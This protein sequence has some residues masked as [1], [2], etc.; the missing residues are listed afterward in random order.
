[1]YRQNK[2]VAAATF[3]FFAWLLYSGLQFPGVAAYMPIFVACMGMLCSVVLF[4]T[5]CYKE[6]TG[7]KIDFA[8]FFPKK[9]TLQLV[10]AFLLIALYCVLMKIV[11]FVVTSVAF[12]F[13]FSLC[14]GKKEKILQYLILSVVV[15]A[16][17]YFGFGITLNTSFP[18]GILI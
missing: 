7:Q 3:A 18:R 11:G 15:V 10:E 6:K 12:F 5:V 1:M 9:E 13:L 17:I 14:F 16:V 4:V 8:V 2:L